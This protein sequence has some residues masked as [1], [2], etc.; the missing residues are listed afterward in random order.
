MDHTEHMF[1]YNVLVTL[2]LY[3]YAPYPYVVLWSCRSF[4]LRHAPASR[5]RRWFI[6]V[7]RME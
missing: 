3:V 2:A 7:K 6:A 5:P 1:Y 4:G